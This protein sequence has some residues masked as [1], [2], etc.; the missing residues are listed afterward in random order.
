MQ[1][2]Y[3]CNPDDDDPDDPVEE[4]LVL[5]PLDAV[6]EVLD[7]PADPPQPAAISP[8]SSRGPARHAPFQRRERTGTSGVFTPMS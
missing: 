8:T 1:L 4:L 2:T 3:A 7:A 5:E 6:P